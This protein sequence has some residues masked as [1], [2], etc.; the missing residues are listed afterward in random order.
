MY[1]EIKAYC[2]LLAVGLLPFLLFILN[3]S[4]MSSLPACMRMI[5]GTVILLEILWNLTYPPSLF[6]QL[7][8]PS[9]SSLGPALSTN[10]RW[11]QGRNTPG[12]SSVLHRS[13]WPEQWQD[14]SVQCSRKH[15][16][17]QRRGDEAEGM[18]PSAPVPVCGDELGVWRSG[19]V[20]GGVRPLGGA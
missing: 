19:V 8:S 12:L 15:R 14:P 4:E 5:S 9:R 11:K 20:R 18:V 6:A 7:C 17:R 10:V 3:E 13:P 16:A 1:L 2:C